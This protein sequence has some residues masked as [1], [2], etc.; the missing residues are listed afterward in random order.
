MANCT[1]FGLGSSVFSTDYGKA[2]RVAAQLQCGMTNI[3]D[4]AMVPMIGSLPFG[5]CKVRRHT[6][7]LCH[8]RFPTVRH[9]ALDASTVK[10]ASVASVAHNLSSR[11][12]GQFECR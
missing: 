9:P 7:P 12:A 11:T 3:N 10:R 2:H 5:G 1:E 8:Q 6:A 4:F